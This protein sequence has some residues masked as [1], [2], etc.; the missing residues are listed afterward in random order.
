MIKDVSI[1]EMFATRCGSGP[2][3]AHKSFLPRITAISRLVDG[4]IFLTDS[5]IRLRI[6]EDLLS[7]R[8]I[9][10][11]MFTGLSM[12]IGDVRD[13][14]QGTGEMEWEARVGE[15]AEG[16]WDS[17]TGLRRGWG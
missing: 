13:V 15:A 16:V 6:G 14:R 9:A 10:F 17:C 12:T 4:N 11:S 7:F 5:K 1:L 3:N 2:R 8:S